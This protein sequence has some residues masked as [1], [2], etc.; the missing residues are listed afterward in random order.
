MRAM[1]TRLPLPVLQ[2]LASF[3]LIAPAYHVVSDE[4]LP[5]AR[6][7]YW[8][9]NARE[10]EQELDF[11]LT[12]YEPLSLEDLLRAV[13]EGQEV[14]PNSLLLTFDD[15]Y[16]EVHDV[17]A[18]ILRRKGV[19]AVFF[20]CPAFLD[21]RTLF[22]RNKASILVD[23]L[24]GRSLSRGTQ[25]RL[26]ALL[27]ENG[28]RS[29]DLPGAIKAVDYHHRSALDAAAGVLGV[30][31][32]GYLKQQ[33]P[34]LSTEQVHAL[35]QSGFAIGAHSLDHPLY[36][37]LPL[38][39]QVR[40][41]RESAAFV[42]ERFGVEY[43]AFAFPFNDHGVSRAFFDRVR[44][45]GCVDVSFGT[46][47]GMMDEEV[48]AHF[49]RLSMEW[50]SMPLY[51]VIKNRYRSRIMNRLV[52]NALISRSYHHPAHRGQGGHGAQSVITASSPPPPE[53]V[54]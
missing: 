12:H 36:R 31:L 28:I 13:R 40:Q 52:G 33:R 35:K 43:G 54:R 24:R 51:A 2:R 17:A 34:Y 45:G 5:H 22:F 46:G 1:L 25:H 39:E 4:A 48:P 37:R 49:Q 11:F 38:D 30:D 21:N 10:F 15:G 47:W 44:E 8:Y 50:E 16:R 18:P 29:A 27:S 19:P 20:I 9:R 53:T 14:P 7:L 6:H 3:Q 26:R 41:T 42:K 32:D 23:A